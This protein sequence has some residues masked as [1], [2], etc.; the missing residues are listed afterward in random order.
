MELVLT[1]SG[2]RLAGRAKSL[3]TTVNATLKTAVAAVGTVKA[4]QR[5]K[6]THR[7]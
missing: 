3:D 4:S 6:L 7:R 2:R 1:K 5:V